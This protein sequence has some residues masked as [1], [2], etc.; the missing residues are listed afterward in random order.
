MKTID[1]ID[2]LEQRLAEAFDSLWDGF[3]DPREPFCD[4]G[5]RWLPLAGYGSIDRTL[6]LGP[7]SEAELADI[8]QQ[9][10]WLAL[11]NEFAINGHENRISFIVGSGHNYRATARKGSKRRR[12]SWLKC[13]V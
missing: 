11:E 1:Q 6:A 8:R 9:C 13:N 3:V 7:A 10:R 12:R 4:D 5:E 2:A